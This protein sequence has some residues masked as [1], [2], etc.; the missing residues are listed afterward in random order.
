MYIMTKAKRKLEI[1]LDE[2]DEII[3][4]E[5]K[6]FGNA[7]HIILPQKHKNKKATIIIKK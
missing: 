1:E 3:Q 4:R 6:P 5:V 7:S 2:D